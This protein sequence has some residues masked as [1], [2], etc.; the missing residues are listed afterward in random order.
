MTNLEIQYVLMS[1]VTL[2][3]KRAFN[4]LFKETTC[5]LSLF[6]QN[7]IRL[8]RRNILHFKPLD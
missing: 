1:H 2:D 8:G 6:F 4:N 3:I 7:R 5:L